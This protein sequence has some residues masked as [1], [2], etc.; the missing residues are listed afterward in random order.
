[1]NV[2]L[3]KTSGGPAHEMAGEMAE[4]IKKVIYEYSDKVPVA[5]AIGV[6]EIVKAEIMGEQ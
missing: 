2:K 5:L 6:L 1:M 4:K 3:L